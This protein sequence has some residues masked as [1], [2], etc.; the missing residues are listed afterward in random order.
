LAARIFYGLI[1]L[2]A[3]REQRDA[4]NWATLPEMA[5]QK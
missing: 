2:S 1:V 5:H 4:L 3:H